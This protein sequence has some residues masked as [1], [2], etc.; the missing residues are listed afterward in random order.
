MT[1]EIETRTQATE[2]RTADDGKFELV[3][4]AVA[5]FVPTKINGPGGGFLEQ[6]APSAFTTALK[7]K[8][9]V[10]CTFNHSPNQVLG[11]TK[12]GTCVLTQSDA[13]LTFRCVL[14]K[15]NSLHRD[16]YSA[17]K[18]GDIS[19]CSFA[20]MLQ[21][22]GSGDEWTTSKDEKGNP[23][24]LRT[25]KNVQLLDVSAVTYP[26]YSEG[27][28]CFRSHSASEW[29]APRGTGEAKAYAAHR[30]RIGP[31]ERAHLG[32]IPQARRLPA[33]NAR[34]SAWPQIAATERC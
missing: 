11:R 8:A 2:V 9:D 18:R 4:R 13:G 23:V 19:E 34:T 31:D 24:P 26:A 3:G 1:F 25:L 29:P 15:T 14:D 21:E 30:R 16:V 17:V 7:A 6:V 33:R 10:R 12:S 32:A 27:N 28:K 5:Y 20:F 22:D